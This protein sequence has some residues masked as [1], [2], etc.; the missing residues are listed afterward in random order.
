LRDKILRQRFAKIAKAQEGK[1]F[2]IIIGEKR[3]RCER[4]SLSG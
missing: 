2:G 1:T 3:G 4:V